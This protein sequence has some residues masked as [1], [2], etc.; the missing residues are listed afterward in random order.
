M[1]RMV[2]MVNHIANAWVFAAATRRRRERRWCFRGW[3]R[4]FGWKYEGRWTDGNI[5]RVL[6]RG[7]VWR[8]SGILAPSSCGSP[9]TVVSSFTVLLALRAC[10]AVQNRM[11][12]TGNLS[13]RFCSSR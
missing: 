2:G 8:L 11:S 4:Y 3:G 13:V 12:G 9:P 10:E 5:D 7:P 1:G 6:R